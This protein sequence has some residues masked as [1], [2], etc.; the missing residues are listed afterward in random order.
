MSAGA[1]PRPAFAV[2]MDIKI[3]LIPTTS[4]PALH[5]TD[6]R[7]PDLIGYRP[8]M[9][10]KLAVGVIDLVELPDG[11]DEIGLALGGEAQH[12]SGGPAQ[13]GRTKMLAGQ[14]PLG[15]HQFFI[16]AV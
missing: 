8:L 13:D 4:H 3:R 12:Q 2:R 11:T 6:F 9:F 7:W 5:S 1:L 16:E 15:F 14:H 10:G